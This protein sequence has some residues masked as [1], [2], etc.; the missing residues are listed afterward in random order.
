M[1]YIT[2]DVVIVAAS[3]NNLQWRHNREPEGFSPNKTY[4]VSQQQGRHGGGRA[5]AFRQF[6]SIPFQLL[7]IIAFHHHHH[8]H[9]HRIT[10]N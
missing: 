4:K 10:R 5:I 6:Q 8:H 7:N 2:V 9:H 3:A 1:R